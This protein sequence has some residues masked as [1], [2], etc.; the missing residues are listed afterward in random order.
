ML[1]GLNTITLGQKERNTMRKILRQLTAVLL[2]AALIFSF[3]ACSKKNDATA[4]SSTQTTYTADTELGEGSKTVIVEVKDGEQII[5][6]TIHTDAKT[7]GEA[8]TGNN[9]IEGEEGQYGLYIKSVNGITAD[10][11]VD[12]T[13]WAFYVDGEYA[14]SGVDTT[15]ISEGVVY[16]LE[17][18]K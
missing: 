15:D 12:Q 14:S 17:R 18:T 7:V 2:T 9:L 4:G 16:R 13:Y 6:F 10:Y 11:D 8:L 1:T 5:T 3:A